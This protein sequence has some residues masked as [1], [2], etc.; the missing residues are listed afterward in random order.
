MVQVVVTKCLSKS[1]VLDILNVEDG[2]SIFT[3]DRY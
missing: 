2:E 1:D 3:Y